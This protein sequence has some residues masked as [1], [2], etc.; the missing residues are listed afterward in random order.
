MTLFWGCLSDETDIGQLRLLGFE[1]CP[2]EITANFITGEAK[3]EQICSRSQL[4]N[5]LLGL[6]LRRHSRRNGL[7]INVN[8]LSH[9]MTLGHGVSEGVRANRKLVTYR[10]WLE[11]NTSS[12]VRANLAQ[13]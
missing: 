9:A 3:S 12:T 7:A 4:V 11:S 8:H 10:L 1:F 13:Y 2:C 6:S 5:A